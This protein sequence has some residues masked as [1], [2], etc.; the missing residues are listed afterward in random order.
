MTW[1]ARTRTYTCDLCGKAGFKHDD[2]DHP[3][4]DR[5]RC[6]GCQGKQLPTAPKPPPPSKERVEADKGSPAAEVFFRRMS[7]A[8]WKE[9]HK[10]KGTLNVGAAF[11][12]KNGK[13]YRLWLS[14]SKAKCDAFGNENND[15]SG[16]V[17]KLT[18]KAGLSAA[19]RKIMEPHQKTGVQGK[20]AVVAYHRE[21]FVQNGNVD[22][23]EEMKK[24]L[25]AN[26]HYNVGFT[27]QQ[28]DLLNKN[29]E[30]IDKV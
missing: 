6:K 12:Y 22:T 5:Q 20:P 24:L 27:S 4:A 25:T 13:N 7:E 1:I 23:D 18:F 14:T 26:K 8:E 15:T 17:V 28:K 21:G 16:F 29:I 9:I 30:S 10:N 3:T 19:F 11:A 2:V